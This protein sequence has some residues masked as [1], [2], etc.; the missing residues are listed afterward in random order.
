MYPRV[1]FGAIQ[2]VAP[3]TYYPTTGTV[4]VA[5]TLLS[6]PIRKDL[7]PTLSPSMDPVRLPSGDSI[8][9][10][11]P[12]E[13]LMGQQSPMTPSG[14]LPGYPMGLQSLAPGNAGGATVTVEAP[15]ASPGIPP[16]VLYGALA[17]LA[18]IAF[19]K[20]R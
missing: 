3:R 12:T 6:T 14:L 16:L 10:P 8:V 7:S 5:P 4:S 15:A 2:Y 11:P 20:G 13:V 17:L 19:R 9:L 1:G 18:L